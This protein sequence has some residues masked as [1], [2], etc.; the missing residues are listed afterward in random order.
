MA[1]VLQREQAAF[2]PETSDKTFSLLL[3]DV[4]MVRFLPPLI[5][6][7]VSPSRTKARH[8][9]AFFRSIATRSVG[10]TGHVRS[11]IVQTIPGNG[12]QVM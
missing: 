4:G 3:S 8:E 5:A 2:D 1:D 12:L 6:Y 7:Y 10:W 9:N 11:G